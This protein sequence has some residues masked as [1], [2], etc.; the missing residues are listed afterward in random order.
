MSRF[1]T[2]L[3]LPILLLLLLSGCTSP[4]KQDWHDYQ[5]AVRPTDSER[6][7][8][9]AVADPVM[10]AEPPDPQAIH[11]A[12]RTQISP[13]LERMIQIVSRARP[14]TAEVQEFHRAYLEE[15]R[16]MKRAW[17]TMAVGIEQQNKATLDL[18]N[19]QMNEQSAAM[20]KR[21]AL[22]KALDA[23]YGVATW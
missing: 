18:S 13:C 9:I 5:R 23:K 20:K 12:I 16:L 22:R 15:L 1:T 7:T 11:R 19:Q 14:R 17:E 10:T 21:E 4:T 6:T 2:L 3:V 8:L